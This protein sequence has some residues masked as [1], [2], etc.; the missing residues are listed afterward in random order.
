M[1]HDLPAIGNTQRITPVPA[2]D[3]GLLLLRV[4][5]R[6]S[7][8]LT[9]SELSESI[10]VSRSTVYSLLATLQK[11]GMVEKD[12]RLKTYRLGV[13]TFELGNAYIERVSLI[14]T[15]NDVAQR[16]VAQCRETVKLAVLDGHEVVYLGKQE[17]LHSVRLVARIG[18]RMPAH[19]TAV[20][21]VL[22]A[23]YSDADLR[24]LYTGYTFASRTPHTI[25]SFEQLLTA[26]GSVRQ[27]QIAY[28]R[29]ESSVGLQCVAAPIHDHLGTVIAAISIGV[30]ND[31]LTNERLDQLTVLL[32]HH[33]DEISQQLGWNER[34][35]F[36][37]DHA[38]S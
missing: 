28:D 16:L 36:E 32:V 26:I 5:A 19:A 3:R 24:D 1:L 13:A 20:G 17:G 37:V 34:T 35:T 33:A 6:A 38:H 8:A 21:K 12:P 27:A 18:S 10:G 7:G 9:L 23:R 22:L 29:E 14:P 11:H 2:L 4:L 31:R 25:S 15:F 30:P